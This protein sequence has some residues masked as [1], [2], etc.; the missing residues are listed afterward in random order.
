MLLCYSLQSFTYFEYVLY[1]WYRRTTREL[2][3]SSHRASQT[4]RGQHHTT[5]FLISH[6]ALNS[7]S[8]QPLSRAGEL[9]NIPEHTTMSNEDRRRHDY[10][11]EGSLDYEGRL[12]DSFFQYVSRRRDYDQNEVPWA[13]GG[14]PVQVQMSAYLRKVY[15]TPPEHDTYYHIL[16]FLKLRHRSLLRNLL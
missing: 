11:D 15:D 2:R 13:E 7:D 16:V 10:T 4:N 3:H 1:Y 5:S 9:N 14:K 6:S 8:D 12:Q